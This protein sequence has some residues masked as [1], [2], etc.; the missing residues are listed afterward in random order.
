M[1]AVV[2]IRSI[3]TEEMRVVIL[4]FWLLGRTGSSLLDSQRATRWHWV[5]EQENGVLRGSEEGW[6]D[7]NNNL[8]ILGEGK[9]P[10][11]SF[12]PRDKMKCNL[13]KSGDRIEIASIIII[14]IIIKHVPCALFTFNPHNN[15]KRQTL[16]S[17]VYR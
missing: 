4:E 12:L 14:V 8:Q 3:E 10:D 13:I 5:G 2:F 17:P 9:D 6:K 11:F 16:L 15:P 1:K 7:T